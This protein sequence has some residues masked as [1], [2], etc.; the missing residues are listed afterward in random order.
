[1]I[2]IDHTIV[3]LDVIEKKF[4]CDVQR[5][6][7]ACCVEGDSGAPL[8]NEEIANIQAYL[9]QI[10]VY[11]TEESKKYIKEHGFYYVDSDGDKV[12]QLL[13]NKECVFTCFQ[14]GIALCAIELAYLN[15]AIPLNKPLSCRLYPIRIENYKTF[16]AVN[17]HSWDIWRPAIVKGKTE[18]M[19][20]YEFCKDALCEKFGE[21]WYQKLLKAVEYLKITCKK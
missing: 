17:F 4:S 11:L 8:E 16:T 5:C 13:K 20:V 1:M 18:R 12:T 7:G 2:E 19:A 6:I 10:E 21:E 14:N 15:N 3:S 9:H